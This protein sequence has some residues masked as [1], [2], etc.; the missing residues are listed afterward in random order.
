MNFGSIKCINLYKFLYNLV[1]N[2]RFIC[3]YT[4][5]RR[6]HNRHIQ[7]IYLS[8]ELCS[9]KRIRNLKKSNFCKI[10][11]PCHHEKNDEIWR[12]WVGNFLFSIIFT[13]LKFIMKFYFGLGF[14]VLY[15]QK[16]F[17]KKCENE[18]KFAVGNFSSIMIAQLSVFYGG[19]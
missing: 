3:V 9:H 8:Y 5:F 11:K 18:R 12:N 17:F 13:I 16:I 10:K 4:F 1:T 14:N 15:L 2:I 19:Q 7:F 6:L